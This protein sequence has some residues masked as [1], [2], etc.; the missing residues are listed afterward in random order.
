[1]ERFQSAVGAA[2]EKELGWPGASYAVFKAGVI[3][4]TKAIARAE[5]EN[6]SNVLINSC[7]PGYVR[8]I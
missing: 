4:M 6:D 1:M 2:K 3:G 5:K 7:C 8:Q